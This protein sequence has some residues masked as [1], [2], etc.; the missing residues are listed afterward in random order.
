MFEHRRFK[1]AALAIATAIAVPAVS[2]IATTS[3]QAG[4]G[5]AKY[6]GEVIAKTLTVRSHST[7]HGKNIGTV[8]KGN[9]LSIACKV[10]AVPVDGNRRWYALNGGGS[11]PAPLGEEPGQDAGVVRRSLVVPGHDHEEAVGQP[12]SG[13]GQ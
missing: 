3:A 11:V 10:D 6:P 7:T 12:A 4:G 8:R 5:E 9:V 1:V 2:M 13:A